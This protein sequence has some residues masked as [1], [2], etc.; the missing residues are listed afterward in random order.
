ML[1]T[2]KLQCLVDRSFTQKSAA[3]GSLP[4]FMRSE[5]LMRVRMHT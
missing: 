4:V 3:F 1:N 5:Y 2:I